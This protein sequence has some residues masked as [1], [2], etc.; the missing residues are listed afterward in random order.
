M[1]K[2][3]MMAVDQIRFSKKLSLLLVILVC[4]GATSLGILLSYNKIY[5]YSENSCKRVLSGRIDQTGLIYVKNGEYYSDKAYNFL[6]EAKETGLVKS[7]GTVNDLQTDRLPELL[8]IQD[9]S[10]KML[11]WM[12][13]DETVKD[14]CNLKFSSKLDTT[15]KEEGVFHLY[16]GANFK[17][18]KV[19]T[20]YHVQEEDESEVV[21][22]VS[23]ILEKGEEFISGGIISGSDEGYGVSTYLLDNM[24]I[25]SGK[26]PPPSAFWIYSIDDETSLEDTEEKLSALSEKW[27]L[28]MIFSSL[29]A[30]FAHAKTTGKKL[31]S[32]F[33]E[34][35]ILTIA[36]TIIINLCMFSVV[37]F[38]RMKDYGVLYASG[39]SAGDLMAIFLWENI[40][41]C[42]I[43]FILSGGIVYFLMNR[44]MGDNPDSFR[45]M[46]DIFFHELIGVMAIETIIIIVTIS[47][48]PFCLLKKYPPNRLMKGVF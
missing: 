17:D 15:N 36:G 23:G 47:I 11:T 1:K 13:M 39:F 19:G 5:N 29:S 38:N 33:K 35:F 48:I 30:Y 28:S 6:R 34:L 37:F 20:K 16:L 18:I 42:G 32:I 10:Q 24:V 12:Y 25:F 22:V 44:S 4:M 31:Q 2:W 41:K 27:D 8:K 43:G 40:I 45:M 7:I 21:Y 26:V 14:L 9:P 3:I 46:N